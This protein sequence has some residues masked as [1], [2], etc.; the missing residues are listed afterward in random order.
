M[1]GLF[2]WKAGIWHLVCDEGEFDW[3]PETEEDKLNQSDI[4]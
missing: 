3:F 2:T 4:E 1:N